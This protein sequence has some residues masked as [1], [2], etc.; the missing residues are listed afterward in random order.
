MADIFIS[1][2]REDRSTAERLAKALKA[3]GWSV[4][5]DPRIPAGR[6]FEEVIEQAIDEANSMLVLWSKRALKSTWVR[7]EANEGMGRNILVPVL[8]QDVR[9]PL[10]FRH[11]HAASLI[12][13][14]GKTDHADFIKLV[15]DIAELLGSPPVVVDSPVV[16]EIA[17]E[18]ETPQDTEQ[19][20]HEKAKVDETST[21]FEENTARPTESSLTRRLMPYLG[22]GFIALVIV[23]TLILGDREPSQP[24]AQ[25][26]VDPEATTP[27]AS[28]MAQPEVLPASKRATDVLRLSQSQWR[29][30]QQALNDIGFDAGP[31]DGIPGGKT[32]SAIA[33]FQ[34]DR[35][36]PLT[37]QLDD[38]Q[39]TRLLADAK[40]ASEGRLGY[41]TQS[42][43][44]SALIPEMIEIPAGCFQ[45]GSPEDE[46]GRG[47]DERQHEVCVEAFKIGKTEVTQRQWREVMGDNP[48]RFKGCDNCPVERVSWH[49]VQDYLRKLNARTGKHYRLPTEAEWEYAARAGTT[50]PFSFQGKI[51]ADKA[52]YN[53]N[54]TYA[55]S[56]KGEYREKTVPVGSL[57]ANPWGLHEVH[58]NVWEWTCSLYD[59][60]YAGAERK[61]AGVDAAG[62]RVLRGG[63]WIVSPW[64]LRSADRGRLDSTYRGYYLGFRLVQD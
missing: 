60:D 53:A 17:P 47:D 11:I 59:R 42:D 49:D 50:G 15:S 5:W 16:T 34:E 48:S 18:A 21:A 44:S 56:D 1:Y 8:I 22:V 9:P 30:V 52:N 54:H 24:S 57:P 25:S 35:G 19:D 3:Q 37:G 7:N 51:G 31:N 40:L 38:K 62:Y 29:E 33:L 13:W 64:R 58:G 28:P 39:R 61:C 20:R 12:H 36:F 45:M 46:E 6:S 26:P 55:G 32:I 14:D 4:W 43:D 41:L 23:V 63:S 10:A 27:Q 2:A